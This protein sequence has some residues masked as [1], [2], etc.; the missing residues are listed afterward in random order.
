MSTKT[1]TVSV[2]IELSVDI[3]VPANAD[4]MT[5]NN[6]AKIAAKKEAGP[7]SSDI[8]DWDWEVVSD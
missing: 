6:L 3:E 5:I 7:F 2:R 8:Y 4:E 1:V